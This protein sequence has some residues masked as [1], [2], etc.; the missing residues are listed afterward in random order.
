LERDE[1]ENVGIWID[2][3]VGVSSL[4]ETSEM[5]VAELKFVRELL[6]GIHSVGLDPF[7]EPMLILDLTS[8]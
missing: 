5:L 7:E 2:D 1:L 6:I 4:P 3:H 8:E